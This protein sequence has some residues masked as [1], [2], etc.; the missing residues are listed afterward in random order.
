MMHGSWHNHWYDISGA[1]VPSGACSVQTSVSPEIVCDKGRDI[2]VIYSS[3]QGVHPCGA[4]GDITG[5]LSAGR[6]LIM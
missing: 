1:G 5:F 3:K 4:C 2:F 6:N